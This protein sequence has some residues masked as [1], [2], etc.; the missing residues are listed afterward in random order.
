[1]RVVRY[2]ASSGPIRDAPEEVACRWVGLL[3]TCGVVDRNFGGVPARHPDRLIKWFIEVVLLGVGVNL[4]SSYVVAQDWAWLP[5][6]R[7]VAALLVAV[8]SAGLLRRERYG[9]TRARA[10][11]L[12]ALT[13]YLAVTVWGSVTGWPLAVM[14][15]SVAYLWET[16]VMLMWSTLRSR[17]HV[18]YVAMGT[19]CLLVGSA[20]PLLGIMNP[21]DAWRLG[22]VEGLIRV[23]FL[24]LGV[25]ALL[26]GV[27]VL[28]DRWPLVGVPSLLFGIA[29][30]P[31]GIAALLDDGPWWG[32]AS[33]RPGHSPAAGGRVLAG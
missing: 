21:L 8:P 23:A 27:A 14:S 12:L 15:L 33:T 11:A 5:P 6:A 16:G 2:R 10:M 31:G 29:A 24:L 22:M 19:V 25:G 3:E 26:L 20:F 32:R 13:G 9:T 4:L 18:D 7:F 1:M 28:L 30:L 17:T